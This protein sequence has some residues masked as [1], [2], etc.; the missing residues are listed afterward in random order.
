MILQHYTRWKPKLYDH[1]F[2]CCLYSHFARSK[3][4]GHTCLAHFEQQLGSRDK[5]N[6]APLSL[7]LS[8][9]K[10]Q[11]FCHQLCCCLSRAKLL[12]HFATT[13]A[14]GLS[15]S[16]VIQRSLAPGLFPLSSS[17]NSSVLNQVP[18]ERCVF[19]VFPIFYNNLSCVAWGKARLNVHGMGIKKKLLN[20]LF[21][22]KLNLTFSWPSP[23][24]ARS[25]TQGKSVCSFFW[26]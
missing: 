7:E 5:S 1:S 15:D 8:L 9:P 18:Q 22:L 24:K 11:M 23:T 12:N 13:T 19:A 6:I 25:F 16:L 4:S 14:Q 3:K 17:I 21:L 2:L 26:S 10:N 20:I